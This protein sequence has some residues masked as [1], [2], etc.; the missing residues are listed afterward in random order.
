MG[1][2]ANGFPH[3]LGMCWLK[4]KENRQ[5][6]VLAQC[7]SEG[8]QDCFPLRSKPPENKDRFS[9]KRVNDIANFFV[10]QQQVDELSNFEIV[11]SDN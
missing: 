1:K 3:Y 6:V 4:I 7:F 5:I 2:G 10:V 9:G 8:I 11:Y